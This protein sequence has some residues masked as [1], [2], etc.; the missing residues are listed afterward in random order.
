MHWKTYQNSKVSMIS[1]LPSISFVA[2]RLKK[3]MMKFED[4]LADLRLVVK[5]IHKHQCHTFLRE[6]VVFFNTPKFL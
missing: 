6:N 1:S 4:S 2:R 5:R 3:K